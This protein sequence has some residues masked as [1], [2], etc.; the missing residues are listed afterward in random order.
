MYHGFE[1]GV[2]EST[3]AQLADPQVADASIASE[4]IGRNGYVIVI[5]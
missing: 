3:V 5:L 4:A 2:T 1:N